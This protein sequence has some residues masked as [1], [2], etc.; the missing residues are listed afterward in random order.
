[1]AFI[2]VGLLDMEQWT[3]TFGTGGFKRNLRLWLKEFCSNLQIQ[4]AKW[5]NQ[6]QQSNMFHEKNQ[7]GLYHKLVNY[8]IF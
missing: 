8:L 6:K 7:G 2:V 1:M 4:A 5:S 3:H